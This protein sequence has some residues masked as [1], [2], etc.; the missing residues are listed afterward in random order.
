[1]TS[2]PTHW[3]IRVGNGK[4]FWNSAPRGIWGINS[5]NYSRTKYFK[6]NAKNGDILWF[7]QQ[8]TDG[9]AVAVATFTKTCARELGPLISLTLSDE[10]LY[11]KREKNQEKGWDTEV[12][13]EKLY[14]IQSLELR[15]KNKDP[16]SIKEYKPEQIVCD[17]ISEYANIVRYSSVKALNL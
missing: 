10:E 9:Q 3:L 2:S 13:Y 14:D 5:E 4:N 11:W 12:H 16:G 1:M 17:L 8:N 15:T 6:K 7:I